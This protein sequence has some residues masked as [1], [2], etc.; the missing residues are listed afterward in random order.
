TR[1]STAAVHQQQAATRQHVLP[2]SRQSSQPPQ[3]NAWHGSYNNWHRTQPA[4][5]TPAGGQQQVGGTQHA[6]PS[7]HSSAPPSFH[8]A[9]PTFHYSPPPAA[10]HPSTTT[11]THTSVPST[12]SRPAAPR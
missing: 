6:A 9:A 8:S 3:A 11:T 4:L 7:F 12:T 2:S 1:S 10:Y 5:R